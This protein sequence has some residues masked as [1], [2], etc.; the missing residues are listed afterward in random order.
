MS[1][2]VLVFFGLGHTQVFFPVGLWYVTVISHTVHA[3]YMLQ[4][5]QTTT[6]CMHC[7]QYRLV[8]L[9]QQHALYPNN[10]VIVRAPYT[11]NL[12]IL[13][14]SACTIYDRL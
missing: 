2:W 8:I 5:S 14:Y 11:N 7:K 4:S 6:Q 10:L 12:V 1:K 9:Q 13:P 3:L